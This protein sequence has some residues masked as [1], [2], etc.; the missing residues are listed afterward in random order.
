MNSTH[1]SASQFF[2]Y[3]DEIPEIP[4]TDALAA[5]VIRTRLKVFD[6]RRYGQEIF[7]GDEITVPSKVT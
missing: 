6:V 2:S 4:Y 7:I 1:F 3:P 5:L